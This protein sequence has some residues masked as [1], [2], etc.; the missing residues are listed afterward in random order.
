MYSPS[1]PPTE[2]T[3][4]APTSQESTSQESTSQ[5]ETPLLNNINENVVVDKNSCIICLEEKDGSN[6]S[7][8]SINELPF[9]N[10]SCSCHF[11]I[12]EKCFNLWFFKN[13][14]CPICSSGL[15][16]NEIIIPM[17]YRNINNDNIL[18]FNDDRVSYVKF[19]KNVTLLLFFLTFLSFISFYLYP[20]NQ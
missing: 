17:H 2:S 12:H 7:I 19:L 4:Q 5:E 11:Y 18:S 8:I 14:K 16:Y 20:F 13:P 6:K 1:A 15:S 10:K 9:L 3:S